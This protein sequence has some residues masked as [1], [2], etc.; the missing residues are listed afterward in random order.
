MTMDPP[1]PPAAGG[2]PGERAD[3]LLGHLTA[4]LFVADEPLELGLLARLLDVRPAAV[5]RAAEA[6]RAAPPAGLILQRDGRRVSLATAP[7]SAEY[8][9]RLRGEAG[10]QRLSRAALEVLAIV[11]YRQPATRAEIEAIRG[12]NS[13]HALETLV[14]RGLVTEVG[15]KDTVGRPVLFGTT[16]DFLALAGLTSL[17]DL[18]PAQPADVGRLTGRD[19]DR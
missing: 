13:D 3:E 2:E 7:G 9:R 11:A 1:R 10:P 16:L 12:V 5:E 17:D 18:P 15:R 14:A 4:L 6:L 19:G 8:V